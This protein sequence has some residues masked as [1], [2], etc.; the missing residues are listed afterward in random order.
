MSV[1][2]DGPTSFSYN[3][4]GSVDIRRVHNNT[5]M[6][7]AIEAMKFEL[8]RAREAGA[9]SLKIEAKTRPFVTQAAREVRMPVPSKPTLIDHLDDA[10]DCLGEIS[11]LHGL[12]ED[13]RLAAEIVRARL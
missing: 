6:A 3:S 4:E 7:D 8:E 12:A 2:I 5:E 10:A 13:L 9:I 1:S 11:A